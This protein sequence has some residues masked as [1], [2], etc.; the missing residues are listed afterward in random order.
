MNSDIHNYFIKNENPYDGV[1][2]NFKVAIYVRLS[3]EDDDKS[4]SLSESIINQK[5]SLIKFVLQNR[6]TLVDVYCDDGYSGT[7]FDRPDFKRMIEDIEAGRINMVVTKDMSRLGR[8]YIG[9]GHYIERYFPMKNVRYIALNDGIDTFASTSNNDMGPFKTVINDMYARDISKKVRFSMDGKRHAGKFI[10]AFAPF[11]YKKSEEDRNKLVVDPEAAEVVKRIYR[12]YTEG[13]GIARIA[14]ILNKEEVAAPSLY[15]KQRISKTY[16]HGTGR[17]FLWSH[18]TI[19]KILDNPT[20][21]GNMTQNRYRKV[22]Y[23]VQKLK[24][25]EKSEWITV[26]GTH[27]AIISQEEFDA[28]QQLRAIRGI[29]SVGGSSQSQ[30][31]LLSGLLFCG[32]CGQKMTFS[33]AASN[34]KSFIICSRYKRFK[35]C[36]RHSIEESILNQYVIDHLKNMAE[37]TVNISELEKL[38]KKSNPISFR[39]KNVRNEYEKATK[40]AAELLKLIKLLYEDKLK[41]NIYEADFQAM[42]RE[43]GRE[44]ENLDA[45][46]KVLEQKLHLMESREASD[47]EIPGLI[48]SVLSF[49]NISKGAIAKLIDKIIVYDNMNVAIHYRFRNPF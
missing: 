4:Y 5:D 48:Q 30:G 28:V 1:P 2:V 12:L 45:K 18:E 47:S 8:D 26:N 13:N 37:R 20:Y 24:T 29:Q 25:L 32:D 9:T 23:K 36:S 38:A 27:E 49:K 46:I 17:N 7:N 43:Y 34:K 3:R 40:R 10:G 41:G 11:G 33:R 31:H 19:A 15:K 6:W 16:K 14:D 44:R 21:A 22:S 39:E 35:Q 42:L